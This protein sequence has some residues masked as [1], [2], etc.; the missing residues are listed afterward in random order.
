MKSNTIKI[1]LGETKFANKKSIVPY[2]F[3]AT[4]N[5]LNKPYIHLSSTGN[6]SAD[7][8]LQTIPNAVATEIFYGFRAGELK[9]NKPE[10]LLV[11]LGLAQNIGGAKQIASE[12]KPKEQ[13][14]EQPSVSQTNPVLLESAQTLLMLN[15]AKIA[16]RVGTS[17]LVD[18]QIP[19]G[20]NDVPLMQL[21]LKLE[22][23]KPQPRKKVISLLENRINIVT[24]NIDQLIDEIKI[25]EED[26]AKI[27]IDNE[28]QTI[29]TLEIN[30]QQEEEDFT[31]EKAAENVTEQ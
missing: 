31:E 28:S 26:V 12:I 30:D 3:T 21:M 9:I 15:Q 4:K 14:I 19:D 23:E 24:N 16:D 10:I 18:T 5:S 27:V 22:K 6:I 11:F 20:I 17:R 2:W 29:S 1:S 25:E 7:I 8:D 13:D